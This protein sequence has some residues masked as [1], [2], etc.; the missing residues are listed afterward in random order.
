[1]SSIRCNGWWR[2]GGYVQGRVWENG[3]KRIV[4]QHRFIV[5]KI[6]GR[7]LLSSEDVHH[8]DGNKA[9]NS[10]DNLKILSHSEHSSHTGRTRNI[11]KTKNATS[12]Y[13]GVAKLKTG[14]WSARIKLNGK[15]V[16]GTVVN[17]ELKAARAYDKKA[18]ELGLININFTEGKE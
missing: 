13:F 9:N 16:Y 5:E 14:Y 4:L 6:L 15:I 2:N 1:M 18:K 8:I 11:G 17:S 12:R 10:P 7:V 3:K